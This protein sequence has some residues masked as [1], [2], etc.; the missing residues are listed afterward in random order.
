MLER[1]S[2]IAI[3]KAGWE[4][5]NSEDVLEFLRRC[6]ARDQCDSVGARGALCAAFAEISRDD[7]MGSGTRELILVLIAGTY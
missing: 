4:L 3:V 1:R 7:A 5:E 6:R 2:Y